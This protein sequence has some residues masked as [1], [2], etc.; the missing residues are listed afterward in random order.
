MAEI[1]D[2]VVHGAEALF[3]QFVQ[4]N[5]SLACY[6]DDS[7][8]IPKVFA[9]DEE[10]KLIV[11][12]Q[13]PT[14]KKPKSRKMITTVLNLDKG[15]SLRRYLEDVCHKLGIELDHNVYAT[16]FLKNFFVAPP[17]QIS[18]IDVFEAFGDVWLPFLKE[19]LSAFPRVPVLTLG[20]PLLSALVLEG[21]SAQVRHYWGYRRDWQM[22]P[23]VD[24]R[25][26]AP[27]ENRLGRQL[28]PFPHQLSLRKKFYAE[29]L[30]SY[31]KYMRQELGS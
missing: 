4:D 7:L 6:I 15:G 8:P 24:F 16:N 28:F 17:T 3:R 29:N 23:P 31:I 25:C 2:Q 22:N 5:P 9:G 26:V 27:A 14:V 11:L 12:G 19:E 21:V 30:G 18:S 13:D 1:G 10:I 20:E